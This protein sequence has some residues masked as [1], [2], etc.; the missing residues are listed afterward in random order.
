VPTEHESIPVPVINP[1]NYNRET[2]SQFPKSDVEL[3]NVDQLIVLGSTVGHRVGPD[4][5]KGQTLTTQTSF[6][7]LKVVLPFFSHSQC[8]IVSKSLSLGSS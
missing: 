3:D 4:Q 8:K 6:A 2:C 7:N 5:V 1:G